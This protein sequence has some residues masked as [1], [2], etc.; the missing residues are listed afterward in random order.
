[1]SLTYCCTNKNI[2][3]STLYNSQGVKGDYNLPNIIQ[4]NNKLYLK[5]TQDT[6]GTRI[7]VNEKIQYGQIESTLK[8]SPGSNIVSAFI[9]MADNGDEIDIEF[10]GKDDTV[11][12]TNF[13]YKGIPIYDKNAKFYDTKKKLS[14]SFNKYTIVW[15]PEYYEWKFNDVTLRKLLKNETINF[16]DSPSYVQIGIWKAVPSKWAGP[17]VDW[18]QGPFNISIQNIKIQCQPS[19]STNPRQT[20]VSTTHQPSKTTKR[21]TTSVS[22]KHQPTNEST[23]RQTTSVSTKHQSTSESTSRQTTSVSTKHQRTTSTTNKST[24]EP[25]NNSGS[26]LTNSSNYD[27]KINLVTYTFGSILILFF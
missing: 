23:S 11:I 14:Q 5:L 12:Q 3:F 2:E 7:S 19:I 8:I 27:K 13:F 26:T 17:G 9:L 25:T 18:S 22:T 6:G 24:Q 15:T 20:S 10:V 16:P 1:L 4:Q 21:Q